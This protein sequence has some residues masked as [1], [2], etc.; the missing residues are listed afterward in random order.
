MTL[1]G[2]ATI[3]SAGW[4]PQLPVGLL[5]RGLQTKQVA[6]ALGITVKTADTRGQ[7]AYRKIGV[8]TRAAAALFA[9]QHGLVASGELPIVRRASHW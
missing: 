6:H 8:S 7:R 3:C 1:P 4:R 9:M 2:S 5:A